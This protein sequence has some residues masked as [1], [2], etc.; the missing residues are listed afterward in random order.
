MGS[1]MSK[2]VTGLY[3]GNI[4]DSEDGA[5]LR[6]HGVTHVLSVHTGAKPVLEDAAFQGVHQVHPRVPAPRGRLPRSLPGRG[7]AQH[8]G[9]GGLP[10]DGDRAGL[11]AL[12]GRHQGR[13]L[14][15][16]PQ[17]WLPAAAAGL[18]EH[19][20]GRVPCLDPPGLRQE[21][22]Q[23]PGGAAAPAG[24]TGA[25]G[26]QGELLGCPHGA[27]PSAAPQPK[28]TDE[29]LSSN[30]GPGAGKIWCPPCQTLVLGLTAPR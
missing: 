6:R 13:A 25:G 20:A 17:P 24:P 30:V 12:P 14:L 11:G 7:L 10:D 19:P 5:S 8:H 23:G 27:H 15:R 16:Q 4:R 28:P 29:Q 18:R 26:A 2:V 1:G 3:L 9:A 21:P 22:L